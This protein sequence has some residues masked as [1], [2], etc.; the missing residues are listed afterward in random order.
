ME[1][2]DLDW[3]HVLS[4]SLYVLLEGRDATVLKAL[5]TYGT[6]HPVHGENP[7]SFCNA[8]FVAQLVN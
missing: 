7:I 4:L 2:K 6:T 8:F 1:L 3:R 5:Q